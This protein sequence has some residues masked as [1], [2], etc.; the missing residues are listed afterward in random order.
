MYRDP[1]IVTITYPRTKFE[2][3]DYG[4]NPEDAQVVAPR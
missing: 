4:C 2:L 1:L 3:M